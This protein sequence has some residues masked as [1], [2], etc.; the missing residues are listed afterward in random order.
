MQA[1]WRVMT[2]DGVL[3]YHYQ[4]ENYWLTREWANKMTEKYWRLADR[5]WLSVEPDPPRLGLARPRLAIDCPAEL[6]A[7]GGSCHRYGDQFYPWW[8]FLWTWR[9]RPYPITGVFEP[10]YSFP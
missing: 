5:P 2:K 10:R 8:T 4:N 7:R 6:R 9:N 3:V 1:N